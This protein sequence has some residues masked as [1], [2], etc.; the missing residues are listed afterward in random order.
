MVIFD[1]KA[2]F[3]DNETTWYIKKDPKTLAVLYLSLIRN[4]DTR[5]MSSCLFTSGQKN[6]S[7]IPWH[8]CFKFCIGVFIANFKCFSGLFLVFPLLNLNMY[9]YCQFSKYCQLSIDN[10]AAN[11]TFY[12]RANVFSSDFEEVVT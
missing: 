6:T 10:I 3:V 4:W 8:Y 5:E 1:Y 11:S 9:W 12:F 2:T 7:I